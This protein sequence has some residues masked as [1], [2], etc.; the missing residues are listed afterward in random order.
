[1]LQGWVSVH[2]QI[3]EHW[4]WAEKPFSK[5][6]AWIDMLML[7]NHEDRKFLLGNDLMEIKAGGFYTSEVKLSERWGWS[8][9]KVHA[10]LELLEKDEMVVVKRD[11]KGTAIFLLNYGNFQPVG[12]TKE[13]QKSSAGTAQ[14]QP[15]N[16]NNNYNNYNN[17]NNLYTGKKRKKKKKVDWENNPPSFNLEVLEKELKES[18]DV[19]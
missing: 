2:R 13:Q 18:D 6:Q 15:R 12:T 5:G 14:E 19:V 10:F 1:M 17:D 9:K 7:A 11:S 4:L 16:T 8:R 3:Q